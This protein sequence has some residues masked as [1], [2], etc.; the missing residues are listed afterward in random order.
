M[1]LVGDELQVGGTM[2][3]LLRH[4]PPKESECYRRSRDENDSP[5]AVPRWTNGELARR[6]QEISLCS[7]RNGDVNGRGSLARECAEGR[8]LGS[9]AVV[10]CTN[11]LAPGLSCYVWCRHTPFWQSLVSTVDADG[12]K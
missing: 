3:I 6:D 7:L 8:C 5:R 1:N 12:S 4:T 2:K 11:R 10:G 9:G